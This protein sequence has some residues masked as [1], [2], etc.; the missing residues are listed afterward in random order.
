MKKVMILFSG[1][2]FLVLTALTASPSF[3]EAEFCWKDSYGRGVGTIPESCAAGQ[4]R[5][6]LLCYDQCPAGMKRFGFDCHSVCPAGMDSQGLFCRA[7]EYGRGAGYPWKGKDGFSDKGMF[8]RCEAEQGTGQCEKNLLIVYPKCKPGYHNIGCCICRPNLPNCSALGLGFQLDL[9]CAKKVAIGAPKTG[10][11]SGQEKDAGLCYE[12]CQGGYDG[13]GPVCWGMPP[14]NWVQCGMGAAKDSNTCASI[15]FGQVA[16]VGQMAI[17]VA[18]LGSSTALTAGMSAPAQTSRLT[19][20]K[21][22][23]SAMKVQFD[24][25]KQTNENVARA[26]KA[27]DYANKGKK[28]YTALDTASNAVTDS[29]AVTE[30]DMVRLAAQITAIVDPSGVAAT[31][32][33][34]TYPK[35]SKYFPPTGQGS[36][37][38]SPSTISAPV[39]PA[40]A[41]LAAGMGDAWYLSLSAVS[42]GFT[43]YRWN[44][45]TN[46]WAQVE[47]GLTQ[48]AGGPQGP[49]AINDMKGIFRWVNNTWQQVPGGGRA[50]EIGVGPTGDVWV[51]G[52]AK[53]TGGYNIARWNPSTNTWV[54]MPG[55]ATHIDVG[56]EG[57]WVVNVNGDIFR[58]VNNTTWQQVPGKANGI[59]VGPSGDVWVVGTNPQGSSDFSPQRWNPATNNWQQIYG[60][61]TQIAVGPEGPWAINSKNDIFR[62][63]NNTTWQQVP[64]KAN[65]IGVGPVTWNP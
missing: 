59:G 21:Q 45:S 25:L 29:N 2:V 36:N 48:I 30:E 34:Y 38:P 10:T 6:G 47:G 43:P 24:L 4:D 3:A 9:S 20:L 54:A 31:V 12:N 15:V 60:G 56:P 26:V 28:G 50:N 52:T 1:L 22:Q 55:E 11:C 64:G 35:C 44:P 40:A 5:I 51:L 53:G 27:A 63:V 16:S 46:D 19:K 17:T 33:A 32:G 23:Y 8:E 18:S 62:W 39:A 57:P 42:G 61:I 7:S 37:A 49:W 13:V 14:T 41:P 65:A 58:W